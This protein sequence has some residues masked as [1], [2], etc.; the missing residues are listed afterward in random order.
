MTNKV[1]IAVLI[2][3]LPFTLIGLLMAGIGW[4]MS[5]GFDITANWLENPSD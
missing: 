1:K 5:R 3:F 2:L 4:S